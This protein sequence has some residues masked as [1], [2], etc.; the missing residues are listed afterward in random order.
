MAS[1]ESFTALYR[2]FVSYVQEPKVCIVVI[3]CTVMTARRNHISIRKLVDSS[4]KKRWAP[5][6]RLK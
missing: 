5:K 6:K 3:W 1:S 2:Y 4:L